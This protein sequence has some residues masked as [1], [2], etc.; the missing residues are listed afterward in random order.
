MLS[1]A[2]L[3][4]LARAQIRGKILILFVCSLL[5]GLIGSAV[6]SVLMG[7]GAFIIMPPLMLSLY[8]IY[9]NLTHGIPP[10]I[11][12]IFRGFNNIGKAIALF[13]WQV[14]FV[15]LWTLL[16]IIPGIIKEFAYSMSFY[17][18]AENPNM[19]GL[20]ALKE[21]E[22]M[23]YG[24]KMELFI[25][26]LSFIPWILLTI[27]TFGIAGIYV[28]PYIQA[29][30]ANFYNNLKKAENRWHLTENRD[31]NNAN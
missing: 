19:T 23:M 14:L 28:G 21:S 27:I 6:S 9:L 15:F 12:D 7:I 1:R 24:H 8:M 20:E 5:I 10:E 4:N 25:L 31:V 18:L 17:I 16:L 30:M 22:N 29:T 11:G 26:Q 3:K 13:L 2:E